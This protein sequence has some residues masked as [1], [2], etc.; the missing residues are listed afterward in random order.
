MLRDKYLLL[1][2]RINEWEQPLGSNGCLR[3]IRRNNLKPALNTYCLHKYFYFPGALE[4]VDHEQKH[5]VIVLCPLKRNDYKIMTVGLKD[6]SLLPALYPLE[7]HLYKQALHAPLSESES[8]PSCRLP[9]IQAVPNK[10]HL[11]SSLKFTVHFYDVK[12]QEP[13]LGGPVTGRR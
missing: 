12:T 2:K 9:G 11:L 10:L 3:E 13:G 5:P 8:P 6:A 4:N 7:K 1:R